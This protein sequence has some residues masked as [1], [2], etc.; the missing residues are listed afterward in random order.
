MDMK[1]MLI[2][3]AT[4]MGTLCTFAALILYAMSKIGENS[5]GGVSEAKMIGCAIAAVSAFAAAAY[6]ATQDFTIV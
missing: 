3:I 2:G 6:L 5:G 1:T 4:L